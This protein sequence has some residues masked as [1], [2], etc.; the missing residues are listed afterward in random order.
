MS[1][2]ECPEAGG[3]YR[4]GDRESAIE[5]SLRDSNTNRSKDH[6]TPQKQITL[7]STEST[8][9][10]PNTP[11]EFPAS[12]GNSLKVVDN[13]DCQTFASTANL[14]SG[15]YSLSAVISHLGGPTSG[16]YISHLKQENT[17]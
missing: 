2:P 9:L 16:H 10:A 6:K 5:E 4:L 1:T 12:S 17:G 3:I 8:N 13:L 14:N 7:I 11:E 15:L